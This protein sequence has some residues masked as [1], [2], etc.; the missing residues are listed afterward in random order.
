MGSIILVLFVIVAVLMT[1]L[2]LLQE[3]KGGGLASLGG[4]K[5]A[6]VE[7][8][9]NPIRR[10]TGWLAGM[11][12]VLAIFMALL[13]RPDA[14]RKLV[15][16]PPSVG[17]DASASVGDAMQNASQNLTPEQVK[18]QIQRAMADRPSANP[19]AQT[20]PIPAEVKMPTEIKMDIPKPDAPKVDPAKLDSAKPDAVKPEAPKTDAA[21]VPPVAPAAPPAEKPVVVPEK[22]DAPK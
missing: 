10:A 8:V 3:G 2:I 17:A 4:T 14:G 19:N 7:G 11:F 22:T 18:D 13:H 16:P 20:L 1:F 21:P 9:T 15:T 5:A 12:F 6:A